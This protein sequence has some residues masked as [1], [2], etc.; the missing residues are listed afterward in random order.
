M[1]STNVRQHVLSKSRLK[2][3]D[4]IELKTKFQLTFLG[5]DKETVSVWFDRL[6]L[7]YSGSQR[8]YHT[9][10]HIYDLLLIWDDIPKQVEG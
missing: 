5:F 1:S 3:S 6:V 2:E 9:L 4:F 10:R 8:F 7:L